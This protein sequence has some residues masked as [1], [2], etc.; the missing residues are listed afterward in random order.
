MIDPG[1]VAADIGFDH[2]AYLLRHDLQT[3]GLQGVMRVTTRPKAK[4][5]VKEIGFKH[6][7]E[8]ARNRSLQQ[9]VRHSG[10]P[11][12][13]RAALARTFGYFDPR[14]GGARYVPAFSCLQISS[15]RSSISLA[16]CSVLS[17]SIPLAA[18]RF[19]IRQ[20]SLRNAGVSKCANEVN[21]TCRS[22]LA[23]FAI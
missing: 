5:A 18:F 16:N 23:F 9:P 13:S 14:T 1:E 8:Y 19:I 2:V 7:L 22:S 10:Y 12:R 4:T 17:P 3:Q 11:Q 15:T 6:S 20:V 21:R